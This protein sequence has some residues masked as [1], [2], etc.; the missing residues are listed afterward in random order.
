MQRI[1][2]DDTI[3]GRLRGV[4][5]V[6]KNAGKNNIK[7]YGIWYCFVDKSTPAI[8]DLF[9]IGGGLIEHRAALM[10]NKEYVVLALAYFFYKDLPT[11]LNATNLDYFQVLAFFSKSKSHAMCFRK[12]LIGCESIHK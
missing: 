1:E 4:L 10:A 3:A 6:P 7:T 9:G 2:L 12:R 11:D 5:F 8:L